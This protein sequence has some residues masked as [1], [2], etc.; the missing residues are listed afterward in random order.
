MQSIVFI[1]YN[2]NKLASISETLVNKTLWHN[3]P[4]DNHLQALYFYGSIHANEDYTDKTGFQENG[5]LG[6]QNLTTD[7]LLTL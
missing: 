4:E 5:A 3:N 7:K 1:L 2:N 6:E